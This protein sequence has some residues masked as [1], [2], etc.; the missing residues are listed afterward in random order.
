MNIG[1]I[2]PGNIAHRFAKSLAKHPSGNLTAIACRNEEKGQ[3]FA[4]KFGVEGVYV[5]YDKILED[6]GVDAVYIALPNG[7]HKEWAIRARFGH[8]TWLR[9]ARFGA[10]CGARAVRIVHH[11]PTHSD[12]VLDRGETE[13]QSICSVCSFAREG[14]EIAL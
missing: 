3:A 11:D 6:P 7:F 8:N 10:D 14:E 5:G 2:G 12:A 13:A 4:K 1:I 9:A